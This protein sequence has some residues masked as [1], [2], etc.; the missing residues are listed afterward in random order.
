MLSV[1]LLEV[2]IKVV[3]GHINTIILILNSAFFD[4]VLYHIFPY[5]FLKALFELFEL[6]WISTLMLWNIICYGSLQFTVFVFLKIIKQ[7]YSIDGLLNCSWWN[8]AIKLGKRFY[9]VL[10][11]HIL[12]CITW[13]VIFSFLI[14]L[15]EEILFYWSVYQVLLIFLNL[16]R[17]SPGLDDIIF[18]R[19]IRKSSRTRRRSWSLI[20]YLCVYFHMLSIQRWHIILFLKLW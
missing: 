11:P 3:A 7:L 5:L 14:L 2:L 12:F 13:W 4:R 18:F 9:S 10:F 19:E 1:L 8:I 20:F 16:I 15:I 17:R 6:Q